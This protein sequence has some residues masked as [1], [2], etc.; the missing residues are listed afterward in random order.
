MLKTA[1]IASAVAVLGLSAGASAF[2][3][4]GAGPAPAKPQRSC[5]FANQV[6]GW[7]TDRDERTAYLNVG[8]KDVYKAELFTRCMDLDSALTIG[9]E[10]RGGGS[11]ICDGLDAT[12][13]VRSSMGPQRCQ[14]TKI[15]KMTPEEIAAWKA[16]KKA[17]KK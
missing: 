15:T 11:S 10:S 5:F 12:L 2:A 6:N 13:L 4:E 17:R 16:E 9:L 14:V 3:F 8:T 1:A 7:S